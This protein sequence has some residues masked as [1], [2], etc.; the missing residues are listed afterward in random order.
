MWAQG[1]VQPAAQ[2]EQRLQSWFR[3]SER[4][5]RQLHE[6]DREAYLVMKRAEHLRQQTER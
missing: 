1:L 2:L 4:Y 6:M 3:A 5:P